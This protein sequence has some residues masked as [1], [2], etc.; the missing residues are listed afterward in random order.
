MVI[1]ETVWAWVKKKPLAVC[2][3][4]VK[5]LF[6]LRGCDLFALLFSVHVVSCLKAHLL[7]ITEQGGEGEEINCLGT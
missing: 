1:N 6:S 3:Q 5:A 4:T 2:D 7:V